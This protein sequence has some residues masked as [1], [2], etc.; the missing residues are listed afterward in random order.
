MIVQIFFEWI[1]T[2]DQLWSFFD[3]CQFDNLID[4]LKWQ[5]RKKIRIKPEVFMLTET[6]LYFL[7]YSASRIQEIFCTRCHIIPS[8]YT[9]NGTWPTRENCSLQFYQFLLGNQF[10][11]MEWRVRLK[12]VCRKSVFF[13]PT[14]KCTFYK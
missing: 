3:R 10:L 8:L 2:I 6:E 1:Y 13:S 7:S 12:S 14:F 5:N 11:S 9:C 4:D